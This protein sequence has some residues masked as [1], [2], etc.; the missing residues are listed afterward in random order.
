MNYDFSERNLGEL[1]DFLE[2]FSTVTAANSAT[3]AI[4]DLI[5]LTIAVLGIIGM[6]KMF[7]KAGENGWGSLIPFYKDYYICMKQ[8][9][10]LFLE[11]VF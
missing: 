5:R 6:W 10:S 2:Q 3:S 4:S 11:K 1:E 7:V 9:L 8:F